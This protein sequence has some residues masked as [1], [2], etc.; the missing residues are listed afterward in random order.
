MP[1]TGALLRQTNAFARVVRKH[2]GRFYCNAASGGRAVEQQE[3]C[4]EPSGRSL[5]EGTAKDSGKTGCERKGARILAFAPINS[6]QLS[7]RDA[8][9]QICNL[10]GNARR[11]R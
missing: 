5:A 6:R 4:E 1:G 9:P 2:R 7:R 8:V 10:D 11:L 3:G